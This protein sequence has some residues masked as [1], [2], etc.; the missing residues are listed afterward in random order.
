MRYGI[1][2]IG[3]R[4][5]PR[6]THAESVLVVVI[7]RSHA[8]IESR[9]GLADHSLLELAKVLTDSRIDVLVCGGISHEEREFLSTRHIEVVDN[10]VA[11]TDEV[12][13]ALESGHLNSGFGLES[14]EVP[15]TYSNDRG[16]AQSLQQMREGPQPGSS[17]LNLVDCLAC[18]D[19]ICLNGEPCAAISGRDRELKGEPDTRRVIEA[20]LDISLESERTLCRLSEFIYFSLEMRY[21]RVGL[22]YCVELEEST[23]ILVRVLRRFFKVYPVC[24]KIGG[25]IIAD[26]M[27]APYRSGHHSPGRRIACNPSRQAE[28]LNR[29]DTDIN[30]MSGLCMGA[31]CVFARLSEAPVTA[32]FVKDKSL[33]NNPIGALYSDYYLKEAIQSRIGACADS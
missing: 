6:S 12:V 3:D 15:E 19:R 2:T 17:E 13:A 11:S 8:R 21:Q 14:E 29:L 5:A 20:M 30:I 32:L 9:P 33:A 28:V 22:A 25:S 26:Q 18:H 23:Q 16:D 27:D 7:R 10:V 24:C 31:D 1:P 4:V